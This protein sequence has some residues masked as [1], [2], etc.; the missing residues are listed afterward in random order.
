MKACWALRN[1]A[2]NNQSNKRAIAEA[3]GIESLVAALRCTDAPAAGR[4]FFL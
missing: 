3:G 1:L 4:F 2:A